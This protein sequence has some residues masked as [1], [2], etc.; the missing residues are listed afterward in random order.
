MALGDLLLP[1]IFNVVVY[2]V[3]CHWRS[4]MEEG[5]WGDEMDNSSGD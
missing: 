4:L 1:N 2:A 5:S 3:V